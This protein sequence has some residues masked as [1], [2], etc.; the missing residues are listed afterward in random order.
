MGKLPDIVL[1]VGWDRCLRQEG[2]KG[3]ASYHPVCVR[4]AFGR[5]SPKMLWVGKV[6]LKDQP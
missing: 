3:G 6:G 1:R 2:I 5:Q 4:L